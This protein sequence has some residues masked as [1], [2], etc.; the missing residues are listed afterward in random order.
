MLGRGILHLTANEWENS[1][2][3]ATSSRAVYDMMGP[4]PMDPC[5]DF[6]NPPIFQI[7]G[8]QPR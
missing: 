1:P 7:E 2:V 5:A 3:F 6:Q 4:L 8:P